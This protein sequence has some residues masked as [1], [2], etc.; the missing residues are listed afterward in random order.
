VNVRIFGNLTGLL[1]TLTAGMAG[2]VTGAG[3]VLGPAASYEY[4]GLKV[5]DNVRTSTT[6]GTLDISGTAGCASTCTATTALG[7]SPFVDLYAS[8]IHDP[9]A[10][11][12]YAQVVLQYFVQYSNAPGSYD[13][14]LHAADILDVPAGSYG[15]TNLAFGPAYDASSYTFRSLLVNATHCAGACSP[16]IGTGVDGGPI[17]SY[18]F[19]MV[20]NTPYLVRLIAVISPNDDS[21]VS[22]AM[23]DPSFS[24]DAS[25][26]TFFF[27]AGVVAPVPEP[28]TWA[29][30][31]TGIALLGATQRAASRAR[32]R[33]ST[34][35]RG[36]PRKPKA[37]PSVNC[38]IKP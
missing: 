36:S 8:Q 5:Q 27:S 4:F 1:L 19:S 20:A 7:A 17:G 25:G 18:A 6:V 34:F 11:G 9:L 28:A 21:S 12:G 10:G 16:N 22:H 29:M 38:P 2:A 35:T 31:I 24:T 23:V 30:M 32:F 26:G 13:V 3:P 15:Q 33:R 37:W 14:L